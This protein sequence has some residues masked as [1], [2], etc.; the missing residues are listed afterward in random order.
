M[1]QPVGNTKTT[2][3]EPKK[4]RSWAM[5]L[6]NPVQTV[7]QMEQIFRSLG[8]EAWIFQLEEGVSKTPHFQGCLKFKNPRVWPKDVLPGAHWEPCRNWKQSVAYCQKPEGRLGGPW[9]YGV[10]I[11]QPLKVIEV[12]K[13]WQEQVKE[14]VDEEPDD[15]KI[16]WFWEST[17]NAGKTAMAKFLC[18]KYNA[19]FLSGK[20]ADAKYA[21]SEWVAAKGEVKIAIFGFS[22]SVEDYVSYQALEEI[23]DGIFFTGKYEGKMCMYNP[24]HV[25]VFANF[26]PDESKLSKDRWYIENIDS[27]CD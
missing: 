15:R 23:K 1:E 18:A 19:L 2:G 17:G 27:M 3:K 8:C 10:P 20:A 9:A 11:V 25:I 24:P 12:L 26:P 5:T 7:E 22:R 14:L 16:Y 4:S 13:P 21:V 6:N